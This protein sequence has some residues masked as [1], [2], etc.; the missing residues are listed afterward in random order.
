MADDK[1]RKIERPEPRVNKLNEE[2]AELKKQTAELKELI[3]FQDKK[4]QQLMQQMN[5]VKQTRRRKVI[6][7]S[8]LLNH[9]F[10]H[11]APFL[12]DAMSQ[13]D[14]LPLSPAGR[15]PLHQERDP[16]KVL[17]LTIDW[18]STCDSTRNENCDIGA[19]VCWS[20][21]HGL[22]PT[23]VL[24]SSWER[25]RGFESIGLTH[26]FNIREQW[27]LTD[28]DTTMFVRFVDDINND[29]HTVVSYK[30]QGEIWTFQAYYGV[31]PPVFTKGD[32]YMKNA[33]LRKLDSREM[34]KT[35]DF[36]LPSSSKSGIYTRCIVLMR[37]I[38]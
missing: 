9:F 37:T 1:D 17:A 18:V 30:Y 36:D 24:E 20:I 26:W 6:L 3:S 35:E 5:E 27:L 31:S 10:F 13:K 28:G 16:E 11:N 2:V 22:R 33:L 12:Y 32:I 23:W 25:E 7:L 29:G 15:S 8:E 4:M 34:I 19:R 21:L 38:V 14:F